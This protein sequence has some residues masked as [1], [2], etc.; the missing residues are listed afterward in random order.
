MQTKVTELEKQNHKTITLTVNR[1]LTG[2][3]VPEWDTMLYFKDTTS[4]QEYDQAVFRLQNQYIK[5][6]KDVNGD[7]IKYN[8]KPQTLLVDF[9]PNRMFQMQEQKA[10]I[11][12]VNTEKSGNLD[13]ESRIEK[14]LAISPIITLNNNK[15]KQIEPNDIL[16][17]VREYSSSRSVHDEAVSIAVD[18]SLLEIDVIRAEI[19]KQSEIDSRQGLEIKAADGEGEEL[20]IDAEEPLDIDEPRVS[21]EKLAKEIEENAESFKKKFAMYYSRILFFAFLTDSKVKSLSGIVDSIKTNAENARIAKN[22]GVE[23]NILEL[24]AKYINP[25]I[26]NDLDYK[27]YNINT[28]ANDDSVEPISRAGNAMRKFSRLSDSEIVT[29]EHIASKI[30]D[31]LPENNINNTTKIL[32]IASKQGEFVYAVYK[33]YGKEVANNFYSIPT[34]K[35][36]YEFTRKVY[37]LLELDIDLIETKYTSYDLIDENNTQDQGNT[38]KI[39]EKHMKFDVVVGNPPYQ[40]GDGGAQASARPI[41]NK[42]VEIAKDLNPSY[43]SMII[44]TRWYAGGKGLDSFRDDM[45]NDKHISELHDFLKPDLIFKDINLRGGVCYFLRDN[46]YDNTKQLTKVLT[47]RDDLTPKECMRS[48]KV[49]G[50]DILIR[51]NASIDILTVRFYRVV[52]TFCLKYL[53]SFSYGVKLSIPL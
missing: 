50:A 30:I 15:I 20:D 14:E 31:S 37:R 32:D 5:E 28:L 19:E 39:N 49:E 1:M 35:I 17:A 33:K 2:S 12:N 40:Q 34:S 24:F 51:H 25:F 38:I 48:L 8:M 42:F 7:V 16:D 44:P 46:K 53:S 36:A 29:P 45:L 23:L 18:Y 6:Y 4:A 21:N 47:Y 13:L 43:I 10:L 11:Y 26:L 52:Y 3:T 22:L 9:S 41:Y 27:I